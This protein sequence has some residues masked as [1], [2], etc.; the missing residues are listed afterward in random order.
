MTQIGIIITPADMPLL[1][2]TTIKAFFIAHPKF[3][4]QLSKR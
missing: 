2:Y 4:N 1:D 3:L